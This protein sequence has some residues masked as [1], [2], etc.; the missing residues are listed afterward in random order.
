TKPFGK[1]VN[2]RDLKRN[3]DS[4]LKLFSQIDDTDR[5]LMRNF[6]EYQS[7]FV[8]ALAEL[9]SIALKPQDMDN[10]QDENEKKTFVEAFRL[11]SK[12]VLRLKAFD[13]FDFTKENIGMDEQEFEDYKSKYF[14]IYDEVK[15]KRGEVEKVSILND[16]DFEIEIL[17]NDRINVSYIMDLVRQID[18][19]DKAEQQRNREQIRRILDNADDPTLRLKR[20]LIREFIDEVVPKLSEEDNIDEAYLLFENAKREEEFND[21]AHQQAV[22]EQILKTLTGEFE[23]SGIVNQDHLKDLV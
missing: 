19:K 11:V 14:A 22:D 23:Y 1:I 18:L 2:Y 6:D 4:A 10:V 15:P 3:T 9:K 17:R 5:V 13:E 20:D 16:I 8:D 21:F 7:E 12:L